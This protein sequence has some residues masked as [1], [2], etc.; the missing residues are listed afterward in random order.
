MGPGR[1]TASS[2]SA[3]PW[4]S[5]IYTPGSSAG[6]PLT[7]L[8]SFAAPPPAVLDDADA[9]R[10]R[11]LATVVG[12]AARCSASTPTRSAAA[13]TSC[14][15]TSSTSAW[16]AGRDLDLASLIREIQEP[17]FDRVGVIDL[18]SFYPGQG[19]LRPRHDA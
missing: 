12:P 18:E 3:T 2:G 6:L 15:P 13:S 19:P 7:V 9:L 1:P 5:R 17:P 4:T 16:R 14:S 11:V 8:Q 10:E